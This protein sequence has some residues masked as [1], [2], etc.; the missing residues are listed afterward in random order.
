M[1]M[2][3]MPIMLSQAVISG[4]LMGTVYALL[5]LGLTMVF[6]VMHVINISHGEMLMLGAYVSF[7]LFHQFGLSPLLAIL[8]AAP[9]MFAVGALIEKGIVDKIVEDIETNSLLVT[10]GISICIV[11]I[12]IWLWTTDFKAIPYLSGS[13]FYGCLVFPKPRVVAAVLAIVLT[14]GVYFFLKFSRLGKAIR[15]TA[16]SH[17]LAATCGIYVKRIYLITFGLASAMGGAAGVLASIMFAIYPEM[18]ESFLM[19]S[20]TVIVLGGMGHVVGAMLGGMIL[21]V[22]EGVG[23]LYLSGEGGGAISF[24]ILLLI[25]VFRPTGLMGRRVE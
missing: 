22:A 7:W 17:D 15:A 18:G 10:F 16:G 13:W 21:G 3:I 24:A 5:A 8:A 20:F 9:L 11:N 12:G 14:G 2:E 25:L 1:S 23:S 19:R 6:G 4:I